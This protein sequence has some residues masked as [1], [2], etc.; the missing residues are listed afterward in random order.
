MLRQTFRAAL[1]R[2]A[3]VLEKL[4]NDEVKVRVIHG[5]VGAINESDVM[6]AQTSGAIIVG[7]NVRPDGV[8]KAA[9]ERDGVD[10]RTVPRNLRLH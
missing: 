5:G 6:L 10:M 9:A 7:F 1:R 4:S 2:F 3:T 8:A